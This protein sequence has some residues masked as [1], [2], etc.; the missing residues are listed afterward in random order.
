MRGYVCSNGER[1][2]SEYV[3]GHVVVRG[4]RGKSEGVYVRGYVSIR[5]SSCG[6]S[7]VDSSYSDLK[8]RIV[9]KNGRNGI[10]PTCK[11]R[12]LPLL[13]EK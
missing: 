6:W 4:K 10:P 2:M 7:G 5:A 1:G 3:R 11:M 8:Y 13:P 12:T 9:T